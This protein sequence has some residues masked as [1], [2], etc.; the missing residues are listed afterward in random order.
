MHD[1]LPVPC[2]LQE[3]ARGAIGTPT[4]TQPWQQRVSMA[5]VLLLMCCDGFNVCGV[6]VCAASGGASRR[7]ASLLPPFLSLQLAV[8]IPT[9]CPILFLC[10]TRCCRL[11]P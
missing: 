2:P 8:V 7:H 4:Q 3:P 6:A 11:P 1:L 5:Y 10:A 9:S